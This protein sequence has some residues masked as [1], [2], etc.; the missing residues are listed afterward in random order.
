QSLRVDIQLQVGSTSETIEVQG[1][2]STVETVSSAL[3]QSVT[4]R[5]I[6]NL[7]LNGRNTLDLAL[8]QPG[9]T[10]VNP[11]STA[12]GTFGVGGGRSDSVTYLLDGGGNNNLLSN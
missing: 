3:G 9:V 2:G 11:G 6:V 5:P 10:P 4:S 1:T 8:L 7:P 12:A